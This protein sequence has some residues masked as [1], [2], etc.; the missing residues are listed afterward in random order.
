[1]LKE[2]RLLSHEAKVTESGG[3]DGLQLCKAAEWKAVSFYMSTL[4][5]TSWHGWCC[6]QRGLT[7]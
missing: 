6:S 3:G 7:F 2:S 1:M 4:H 5:G